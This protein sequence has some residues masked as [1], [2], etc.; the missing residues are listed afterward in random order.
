MFHREESHHFGFFSGLVVGGTLGALA[1]LLCTTKTGQRV[2][3]DISEKCSELEA[4]AENFVKNQVK[5]ALK[6]KRVRPRK[7]TAN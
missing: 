5:T 2:K 6:K 7:S 1:A 4:G 3:R